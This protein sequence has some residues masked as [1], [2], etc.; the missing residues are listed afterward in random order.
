LG[1]PCQP[2]AKNLSLTKRQGLAT[3]R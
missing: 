3:L 1:G 2:P